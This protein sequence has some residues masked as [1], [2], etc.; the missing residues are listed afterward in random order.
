MLVCVISTFLSTSAAS[1]YQPWNLNN[2]VALWVLWGIGSKL[3][4]R[5]DDLRLGDF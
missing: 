3:L 2:E 1:L 5:N 4:N